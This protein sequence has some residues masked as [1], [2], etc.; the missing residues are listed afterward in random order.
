MTGRIFQNYH[1]SRCHNYDH[2]EVWNI[3]TACTSALLSGFKSV[4]DTLVNDDDCSIINE[5]PDSSKTFVRK[6]QCFGEPGGSICNK[7]G[8]NLTHIDA[9]ARYWLPYFYDFAGKANTFKNV[10]CFMCS[11]FFRSMSSVPEVCD[12]GEDGT[13]KTD[14]AFGFVLN[15]RILKAE[16]DYEALVCD[17]DELLDMRLVCTQYIYIDTLV[18]CLWDNHQDRETCPVNIARKR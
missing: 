18:G 16:E 4:A 14:V 3:R 17:I 12:K 13:T 1:C 15:F 8:A 5:V 11:G 2:I 6:Y 9:C 10:Y 7:T